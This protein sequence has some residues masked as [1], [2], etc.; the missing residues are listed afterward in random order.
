MQSALFWLRLCCKPDQSSYDRPEEGGHQDAHDQ[1]IE[2]VADQQVI[3]G[4]R[5]FDQQRE[6]CHAALES[7]FF[8]PG[9]IV[10]QQEQEEIA[11]DPADIRHIKDRG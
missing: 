10:L 3:Y 4:Q 2:N 1:V 7:A 8:L 5:R 11:A 9:Q 6:P